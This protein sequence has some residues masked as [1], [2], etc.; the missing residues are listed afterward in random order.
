MAPDSAGGYW[1][2]TASGRVRSHDG[3]TSNASLRHGEASAPIV[4]IAATPDGG[5]YWLAASNGQVFPFGDA[6]AE[7]P[8][9]TDTPTAPIVGIAA[10]PDGGGYWLAASNGQVLAFGDAQDD[11]S[12]ATVQLVK[13]IVSITP[14]P[15]GGGYWLVA[16]DGGVFAF[17]DAAFDGSAAAQ[18][19][20]RHFVGMSPN[21]DGAGYWLVTSD[22]HV[23]NFGDAPYYGSLGGTGAHVQGVVVGPEQPGYTLVES[24][25]TSQTFGSTGSSGSSGSS[26][27]TGTTSTPPT[28]TG[29]P[30]PTSPHVMVIMMENESISGII[31]D[32]SLPYIN[33]TLVP[34]YPVLQDNY[35][36]GHPSLPNY[37]ELLSGST[38]GVTSDC[39]PA[40]G[41]EG[42][43]NLAEQLD[44]AGIRWAGYMESMPSAGY[45]GG[46][47]GGDD[48]YGDQLY[49][50]HHN[51]FVYFPDLASELTTH[52]KPL[53]SMISD[54]DSAN[55]PA[56][57][58]VTPNMLDDGHDG[59]LTTMDTWLSEEIPAIQATTW[60]DEGG[61]IILTWDE[62]A[63]SDTSGLGGGAGGHIPG[64]LI[65]QALFNGPDYT[66]PVDQAGILGSIETLYGL[67]LLN[68]AANPAHGSLGSELSG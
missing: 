17:G 4:G 63:D 61:Q 40:P 31:G 53:T 54:L 26:G 16:S 13:P 29:S 46:D 35:A 11:G 59:P 50:Q 48:G 60:Y 1:T 5:G 39:A 23:V 3:A 8:V 7:S 25:G 55:P 32:S 37:L 24:N 18:K 52:V 19:P 36:V 56:F 28:T 42:S 68:D 47:T 2:T 57:V 43:S 34:H 20:H 21:P 49:A 45:T 65:S 44:Q 64:I 27:S 41:C 9:S 51:P 10:T 30:T 33:N 62:G 14:T 15:D 6:Q 67:P 38:S 12:A 58:W 22:G 66:S